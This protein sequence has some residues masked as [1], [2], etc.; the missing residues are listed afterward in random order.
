MSLSEKITSL[1]TML[2]EAESEIKSLEGGRKASSA[3]ARKSL[4]SIKTECHGLRKG[5]TNY[6]KSMETKTRVKK[7]AEPVEP[8]P[9]SPKLEE[10]PMPDKPLK[11]KRSRAVKKQTQE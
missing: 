3:R 2:T 8:Q 5:V 10:E 1:R 11:L 4:Q 7:E 6:V 9:E